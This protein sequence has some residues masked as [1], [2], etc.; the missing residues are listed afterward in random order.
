MV[1]NVVNPARSSVVNLA[2]RISLGCE[3]QSVLLCYLNLV[4]AYMTRAIEV[5]VLSNEGARHQVVE[6]SLVS[7]NE[8]HLVC[9]MGSEEAKHDGE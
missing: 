9:R 8:A 5:K 4:V 2:L 3:S 1:K 7:L 6:R